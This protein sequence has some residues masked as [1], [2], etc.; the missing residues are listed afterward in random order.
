MLLISV[1]EG[2]AQLTNPLLNEVMVKGVG[3][4]MCCQTMSGVESRG[5]CGERWWVRR[6]FWRAFQFHPT[7]LAA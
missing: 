5:S 4:V 2:D 6:L 7:M 1:S 3:A